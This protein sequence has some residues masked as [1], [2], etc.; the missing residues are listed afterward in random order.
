MTGAGVFY[1]I[2]REASA[3]NGK[4]LRLFSGPI[5]CSS[6]EGG[7]K[8]RGT[9]ERVRVQRG[10]HFL[11]ARKRKLVHDSHGLGPFL[12]VDELGI[13][14]NCLPSWPER[15]SIWQIYQC[16]FQ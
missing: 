13:G 5:M 12:D 9:S 1:A 4:R 10:G 6:Y 2:I 16:S 15:R 7:E 11:S 14:R 3:V 8:R